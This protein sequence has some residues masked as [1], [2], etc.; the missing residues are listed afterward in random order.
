M[1]DSVSV[2]GVDVPTRTGGFVRRELV[3]HPGSVVIV[4]VLDDGWVCL[5]KNWRYSA[6]QHL[7]EL[8]AGTLEAGEPALTAARRELEE[9]TGY[10]ADHWEPMTNFW[11]S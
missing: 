7:L 8:P 3:T 6:N 5:I 2:Y 1:P 11:V 4:P 10:S 9:E